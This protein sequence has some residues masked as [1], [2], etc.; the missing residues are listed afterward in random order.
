MNIPSTQSEKQDLYSKRDAC[1]KELTP[2]HLKRTSKDWRRGLITDGPWQ[3]HTLKLRLDKRLR[4][5][6]F[7]LDGHWVF[8]ISVDRFRD[9]SEA[10]GWIRHLASET[11]I[12][13][14]TIADLCA[15]LIEVI[16]SH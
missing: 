9:A 13:T 3:G 10:L 16:D 5:I 1:A 7:I 12:T 14:Q 8:E 2:D 11:W 4:N 6:D 15:L